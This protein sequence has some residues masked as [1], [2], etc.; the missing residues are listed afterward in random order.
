MKTTSTRARHLG[1]AALLGL[2]SAAG[3]QTQDSGDAQDFDLDSL[4][5]EEPAAEAPPPAAATES[6]PQPQQQASQQPE[7][8][9]Q[10][11]TAAQVAEP[12]EPAE[13]IETVETIPVQPLHPEKEPAPLAEAPH[14]PQ[15]EEII[16]TA[17]KREQSV[18]EIPL[19]IAALTGEKLEELGAHKLKDFIQLV[20]GMNTQDEI[21]GIPRKLSV[22]GVGPDT[23]TNQTVGVVF[24][25]M[26]LTDPYGSFTIA[27]PDPWDLATVEVLKG[28]QGTLFGAT[29]LGGLIRYV[30]NKPKFDTWEGRGSVDWVSVSGGESAL[31]YAGMLNVPVGESFALRVAG[32]LQHQPGV[33]D[34][35]T[36]GRVEDNVDDQDNFA[37]R[38]IA[39]WQPLDE[40]SLNL[41]YM[42]SQRK[43]DELGYTTNDQHRPRDEAP[44]P[45]PYENGFTATTLDARY[46]FDWAQLVSVSGYQTKLAYAD[47]DT[48]YLVR[49]AAMAGIRSVHAE[50]LVETTGLLQELRLVST[51]DG[52][53]TWLGGVFYSGYEA[54]ITG[55]L[56]IFPGFEALGSLLQQLPPG[57]LGL[58]IDG[59]SIT[60]TE[61]GFHPLE[62]EESALFGEVSRMFGSDWTLTLGGR[63]YRTSVSGTPPAN[64]RGGGSADADSTLEQKSNGF[65]PKIALSWKPS[66]D[67]MLYG[68]ISRGFQFGGFNLSVVGPVPLTYE[69]S[70]LWNHEIG[71][72]SDWFE[73]TLRFDLTAFYLDWTRPQVRQVGVFPTDSYIANVGSAS[74]TG[75]ETT[76]RWLPPLEG[77]SL[78]VSASYI[79]AVTTEEFESSSSGTIP[80]GTEMPSSPKLQA[81]A[82][83]SYAH[84]FGNWQTM[85]SLIGT[86]QGKAFNNIEHAVEV[87]GYE[88]LHFNLGISRPDLSFRPSLSIGVNNIFDTA[89]ISAALGGAEAEELLVG[90]PLVYTTPRTL[91]I[92]LSASF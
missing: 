90:R 3:A 35:D 89:A 57:F 4:L 84:A 58:P 66:D 21:A 48:S 26:P 61:T 86:H 14:R 53:W 25:D 76:I 52:P 38:A 8:Q 37:G 31:S 28:P 79:K 73:R 51:G 23:N 11:E 41:S 54:E 88:L 12:A 42:R 39:L 43:G 82:T 20:P 6:P 15:I 63:Y 71:L 47:A 18:R 75:V 55:K 72:R 29:S 44:A 16:V 74:S 83:I 80:E 17:T 34:I 40:L 32:S 91:R 67:L 9:A 45:S 10:Q 36:P 33:I 56:Q 59:D 77:L 68:N 50:R 24:G 78:E 69:S 85:S 70:T 22:R 27:D 87:G 64:Q 46:D 30:P 62:A 92:N 5:A 60:G 49:P 19:S 7:E 65:S 1:A 81:T 2:S 13:A